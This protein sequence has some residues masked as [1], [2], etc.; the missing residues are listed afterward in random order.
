MQIP[1]F[2]VRA[3]MV[4]VGIAAVVTW[5]G[6]MVWRSLAY[7]RLANQYSF[8]EKGWREIAEKRHGSEKWDARG[9]AFASECAEYFAMLTEKYRRAM[10]RPWLPVEPDPYAPGAEE[11]IRAHPGAPYPPP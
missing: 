2:S 4:G 3:L 10:W 6:I 11:Y 8:Q 7:S 5:G 9:V 1:R